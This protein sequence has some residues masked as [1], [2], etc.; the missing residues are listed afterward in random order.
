[1]VMKSKADSISISFWFALMILCQPTGSF[2]Q[3][4]A[5]GSMSV[6]GTQQSQLAKTVMYPIAVAPAN[7]NTFATP[8][9]YFKGDIYTAN[10]EPAIGPSTK[11]NLRTVVRKGVKDAQTGNWEWQAFTIDDT[12]LDDMYHT[13]PSIAVDKNGFI[14][15]AYNMHNMPWQYYVSK[16]PRDVSKFDFKGESFSPEEKIKLVTQN[17]V[18]APGLGKAAIPGNHITYPSFFYDQNRELYITYRFSAKPKRT[19]KKG[20]YSGGIDKYDTAT[21]TWIP[22]GGDLGITKDDA[23]LPNN[24]QTAI[25]KAF[26]AQDNWWVY[27]I[28]LAFDSD[29]AMHVAWL[30]RRDSAGPDASDP[31]YAFSPNQIDFYRKDGSKYALPIPV[32]ATDRIV[33]KDIYE[34]FLVP[35]SFATGPNN[36]PYAVL[37]AREPV[38]QRVLTYLNPLTKQWSNPSLMPWGATQIAFDDLGGQWAFATGLTVFYR[39]LSTMPWEMVYKD[40][41]EKDYYAPKVLSVPEERMFLIHNQSCDNQRVR[42]LGIKWGN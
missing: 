38:E 7:L 20:M 41:G 5:P 18:S 37:L 29:N 11:T 31:S 26:A 1:M 22:I 14:H 34:K 16:L 30:W 21:Q 13:A 40:P 6:V 8:V 9:A 42:I 33:E 10:I 17:S 27:C 19:Y 25:I 39:R 23:N 32:T 28:R 35:I 3:V 24:D 36:T 2:A 15:V 12:T 4:T